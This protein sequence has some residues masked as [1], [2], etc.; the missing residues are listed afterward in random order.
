MDRPLIP[1][2]SPVLSIVPANLDELARLSAMIFDGGLAPK[3]MQNAQAVG[4]AILYGLELGLKPMTALNKI[5]IINGRPAIWGDAALALVMAAPMFEDISE[6]IGGDGDARTAT[7][8]V[9]RRGKETPV[10]RTF[11]VADAKRA[12]LWDER[13]IVK[14]RRKDGTYYDTNNDSPWHKYP[15]RMLQMRARGF[16]LRDAFPDV[17]SG[18]YLA[19]ELDAPK[20]ITDSV[21]LSQDG[22]PAPPPRGEPPIPPAPPEPISIRE[23]PGAYQG[24]ISGSADM[25]RSDAARLIDALRD[26]AWMHAEEGEAVFM[27]FWGGLTGAERECLDYDDLIESAKKAGP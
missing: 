26:D 7:C 14:R 10:V 25:A 18:L 1:A 8:E 19:E 22:P 27:R 4:T 2:G 5:A 16:A 3:D 9:I 12:D 23:K 13:K 15:D 17:L 24:Y 11:S 21:V 20:D 6:T